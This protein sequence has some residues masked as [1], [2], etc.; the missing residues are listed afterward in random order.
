M[1]DTARIICR[2]FSRINSARSARGDQPG[3]RHREPVVQAVRRFSVNRG[4][5]TTV[6]RY[7]GTQGDR[8]CRPI[9]PY[10]NV[11][12]PP[13]TLVVK[14]PG[15]WAGG[16]PFIL[17]I[18]TRMWV[19]HPEPVLNEVEGRFSKGGK[20]RCLRPH[21]STQSANHSPSP[22]PLPASAYRRKLWR[23]PGWSQITRPEQCASPL[24]TFLVEPHSP[25]VVQRAAKT[26]QS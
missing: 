11:G 9:R 13:S 19:P 6:R 18:V 3:Q 16:P 2:D 5:G 23:A 25:T 24:L 21:A 20:Q 22:H 12:T 7:Q 4:N 26:P 17:S 1:T 14:Q 10:P 15:G 8:G